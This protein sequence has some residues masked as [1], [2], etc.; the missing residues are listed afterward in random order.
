MLRLCITIYEIQT[1]LRKVILGRRNPPMASLLF[2]SFLLVGLGFV[3]YALAV[4]LATSKFQWRHLL[5]YVVSLV[6][7]LLIVPR[8]AVINFG[9]ITTRS[10]FVYWVLTVPLAP[11]GGF[12]MF[13]WNTISGFFGKRTVETEQEEREQRRQAIAAR[14]ANY[15]ALKAQRLPRSTADFLTVGAKIDGEEFPTHIGIEEE[16]D[17]V[18]LQASL[19]FQHA[20]VI[21]TTGAG[22]TQLLLRLIDE[23][24]RNTKMRVYVIDGKGDL[25]FAHQVATLAQQYGRG[26]VPIFMMGQPASAQATSSLYDGFR[27]DPDVIANRLSMM[28]SVDK[29]S[30]NALHYSETYKGLVQ[31]ICGVG[32]P[33]LGINPP[34]NFDVVLERL[35]F[36]WLSQTYAQIPHELEAITAAYEGKEN[37]IASANARL[38][39]L[40]R[41]FSS[42]INQDGFNLEQSQCA[43]FSLRTQSVSLDA[44]RLLDF[45]IEDV[46][47]WIGKRQLPDT[48][49]LLIIDEFGSFNNESITDVLTLARSSKVGVILATQDV[50]TLG[51][52]RTKR[53]ILATCNTYFLMKTNFPEELVELAGTIYEVEPSYQMENGEPTGMQSARIQHQFKI[54]PNDVAKVLPGQCYIINSRYMVKIHVSEV[55]PIQLNPQAI[56]SHFVKKQSTTPQE[57]KTTHAPA[58]QQQQTNNFPSI[59]D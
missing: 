10:L 40:A 19:F 50:A 52:D 22:K 15:A 36:Q 29:T 9:S 12:A 44:K 33:Q 49:A 32:Y 28:L 57:S 39:N 1:R 53:K 45:L 26:Q 7:L 59:P 2:H 18:K 51:S 43:V 31:L 47:D 14:Q 20:F 56:A 42:I 4:V 48:E 5:F 46:K 11:M 35:T 34:E 55:G 8:F 6:Y 37:L 54:R 25:A 21:G 13:S 30:G 23:T 58:N 27:G 38:S 24:L 16:S 41:P 17:Y 3:A